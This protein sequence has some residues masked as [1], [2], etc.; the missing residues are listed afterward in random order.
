M[1][2]MRIRFRNC[3]RRAVLQ[4]LFFAFSNY[5]SV[6]VLHYVFCGRY[7]LPPLSNYTFS[8]IFMSSTYKCNTFCCKKLKLSRYKPAEVQRVP[9]N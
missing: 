2:C 4:L 1:I 7:V 9:G 5:V 3:I 6:V 8:W